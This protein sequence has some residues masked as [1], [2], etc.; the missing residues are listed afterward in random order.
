MK[1]KQNIQ[2]FQHDYDSFEAL[3]FCNLPSSKKSLTVDKVKER[4]QNALDN[5]LKNIENKELAI[6]FHFA[7]CHV[8]RVQLVVYTHLR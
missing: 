8:M 3:G 5:G 2:Q 6:P 7:F 4:I 1:K